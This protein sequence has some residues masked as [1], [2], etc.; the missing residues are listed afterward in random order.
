M[1]FKAWKGL[2]GVGIVTHIN[3]FGLYLYIMQRR[4]YIMKG[5]QGQHALFMLGRTL[6]MVFFSLV[7][8]ELQCDNIQAQLPKLTVPVL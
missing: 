1:N 6:R 5:L 8:L 3:A 7:R 2:G 4:I